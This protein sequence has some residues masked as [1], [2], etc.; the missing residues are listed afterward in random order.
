[1]STEHDI[2]N[3]ILNNDV[4]KLKAHL[5]LY[6]ESEYVKVNGRNIVDYASLLISNGIESYD[7]LDYLCSKS[8]DIRDSYRT[9]MGRK[10]IFDSDTTCG[11]VTDLFI[12]N[13]SQY[14]VPAHEDASEINDTL[15]SMVI[16]HVSER[17]IKE[18][19]DNKL[20]DRVGKDSIDQASDLWSGSTIISLYENSHSQEVKDLMV[21]KMLKS[22]SMESVMRALSPV[23]PHKFYNGHTVWDMVIKYAR[24]D[25]MCELMRGGVKVHLSN[26][27]NTA[28]DLESMSNAVILS[29][30]E[31][32]S[33]TCDSQMDGLIRMSGAKVKSIMVSVLTEK[34]LC[35]E[36]GDPC[37]QV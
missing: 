35:C 24:V 12:R 14:G 18:L 22:E 15:N 1:M 37:F 8:I 10:R 7:V 19:C 23:D 34:E 17:S 31:Y 5:S 4:E 9:I 26:A 6:P 32:M 21:D 20:I 33:N 29:L 27:A 13:L 2:K 28:K 3:M 11:C 30:S 25:V 16:H 36:G